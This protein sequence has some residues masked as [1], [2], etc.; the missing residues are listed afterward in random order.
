MEYFF[1][2]KWHFQIVQLEIFSKYLV[3][4][5]NFNEDKKKDIRVS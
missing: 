2:E 5:G 1:N 3:P 4:Y